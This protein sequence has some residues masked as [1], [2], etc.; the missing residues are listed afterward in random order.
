MTYRPSL[1]FLLASGLVVATNAQNTTENTSAD[2]TV[3]W[4]SGPTTR[5]TLNLVWSCLSIIFSCTW[6]VLHLNVPG[7]DDSALTKVLRKT[8]WMIINIL[9]PEF[10]LYKALCD[11]GQA[12]YELREIDRELCKNSVEGKMSYRYHGQMRE[13][14]WRWE[15]EYP[16]DLFYK[17]WGWLWLQPFLLPLPKQRQA[18]SSNQPNKNSTTT[19][20]ESPTQD[21]ATSKFPGLEN[22]SR[23]T[24]DPRVQDQVGVVGRQ[25]CQSGQIG[26]PLESALET[27]KQ[28]QEHCDDQQLAD[29]YEEQ[30]SEKSGK[31][32]SSRN[33]QS[34]YSTGAREEEPQ[35]QEHTQN[36]PEKARAEEDEE[37]SVW[38][39]LQQREEDQQELSRPNV[40]KGTTTHSYYAQM[41]GIVNQSF[42]GR[43]HLQIL[44][45]E[46]LP[47]DLAI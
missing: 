14:K 34:T 7:L 15:V 19:P 18:E 2:A 29:T 6:S 42:F 40:Q 41:G 22:E 10:V 3:G 46:S 27:P 45:S 36:N 28:L 31:E 5:G 21:H 9:F 30:L 32:S 35:G 38:P 25:N 37:H 13:Y 24:S 16:N 39:F 47:T 44:F 33:A 8:K 23:S 11:L 26:V 43:N 12:L 4:E 20:Q 1:C 17:F